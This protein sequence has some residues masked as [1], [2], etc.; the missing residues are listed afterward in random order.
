[1]AERRSL[2]DL[3]QLEQRKIKKVS[4]NKFFSFLGG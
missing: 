1:M 4:Q 2:I 3:L